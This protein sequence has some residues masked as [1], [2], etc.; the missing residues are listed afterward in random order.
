MKKKTRI[1]FYTEDGILMNDRL[2]EQ[3]PEFYSGPKET[4]D[5]PIRIEFSLLEE[6]DIEK[7]IEYLKKLTG[8]L[9]ASAKKGRKSLISNHNPSEFREKV[10][11]NAEKKHMDNQDDFIEY[12]RENGFSFVD[13]SY[14]VD[15]GLTD[16]IKKLYSDKY[17]WMMKRI[18]KAKDPANDKYDPTLIIGVKLLDKDNN[19]KR[20]DKV[21]VY[22][23]GDENIYKIPLPELPKFSFNKSESLKFPHYMI[24]DERDKFRLEYR[25]LQED[26]NKKPSKFYNRWVEFVKIPDK[27]G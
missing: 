25:K 24:Q 27:K 23:A 19:P 9:P 1:Q 4:H 22:S 5:G 18:K 3:D 6:N 8:K 2:V 26:P 10:W 21:I 11:N 7:C 17:F 20:S 12:F 14:I 13:Y 15:N 16:K